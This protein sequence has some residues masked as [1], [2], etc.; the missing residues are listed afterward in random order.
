MSVLHG[1]GRSLATRKR[2]LALAWAGTLVVSALVVDL[3]PAG[4]TGKATDRISITTGTCVASWAAPPVGRDTFVIENQ[5]T[6]SGAIFLFDPYTGRTLGSRSGLQPGATATMQVRVKPGHYT[7]GCHM[8]GLAHYQSVDVTVRP[9]PVMTAAGPTTEISVSPAQLAGPLSAYRTYVTQQLGLLATEVTELHSAIASGQLGAAESAWLTAHL[10]WQRLGAAYDA[11]GTLGTEINGL[12]TGQNVG[13]IPGTPGGADF[14]GFH[15]IE[16]DL[17]G[18]QDLD[19]AGTDAGQLATNLTL[20][21]AKFP[22]D[23]IP[24]AELPLRTHEILEDSQRDE[25]SGDDD[26]GSGTDMA[27][28]QADVEGERVLLQILAPLLKERAPELV[29]RVTAQLDRLDAALA[30]TQQGGQW[31]AV[32][33]VPLALREQVDGAIGAALEILA[34]IPDVMPVTGSNL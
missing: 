16:L 7:W 8:Q 1:S 3:P 17:W 18:H 9:A 29:A 33:R 34:V 26:Y 2:F 13:D 23:D 12:A 4:A 31:V 24:P 27:S 28:V 15:K 14:E 20:L 22:L 6:R 11:F 30:A 19:T 25:L 10:T 5:T 21:T 32:A